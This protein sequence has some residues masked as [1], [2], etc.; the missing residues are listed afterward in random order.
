MSGTCNLTPRPDKNRQGPACTHTQFH[1]NLGLLCYI[2][3]AVTYRMLHAV[4]MLNKGV[5]F[6]LQICI[7]VCAP[8]EEVGNSKSR[9]SY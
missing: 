8:A 7:L 9:S 5:Q 4:F 3:T 1:R 2:H 6:Q